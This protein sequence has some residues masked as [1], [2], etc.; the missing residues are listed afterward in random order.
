VAQNPNYS[1][2]DIRQILNLAASRQESQGLSSDLLRRSAAE[3]GISEEHLAAAEEEYRANRERTAA[4]AQ[5]EAKR[6]DAFY[7]SLVT[8]LLVNVF[9][10]YLSL[11]GGDYWFLWVLGFW[12][13]SVFQ[14]A[15]S[16][17][18]PNRNAAFDRWQADQQKTPVPDIT[19]VID[20]YRRESG[21]KLLEE[22]LHAIKFVRENTSLSLEEAKK[23]VENHQIAAD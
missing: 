10:A 15:V 17:F 14:N 7:R 5:F 13:M 19:T 11:K 12:G 20:Q 22:K 1:D 9:L 8:Y 2:E 3:L 18:G 6:R 4:R 23:L 21:D 16:V